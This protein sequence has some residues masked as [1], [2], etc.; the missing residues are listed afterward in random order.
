MGNSLRAKPF[1][2]NARHTASLLSSVASFAMIIVSPTWKWPP[3]GGGNS[4]IRI[5]PVSGRGVEFR[6]LDRRQFGE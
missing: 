2:S 1:R 6:E 4:V 5:S 3:W